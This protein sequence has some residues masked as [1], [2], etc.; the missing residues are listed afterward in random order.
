MAASGHSKTLES[1][2]LEKPRFLENSAGISFLYGTL[3]SS[4][5]WLLPTTLLSPYTLLLLGTLLSSCALLLLGYFLFS[6][7]LLLLLI[8]LSSCTLLLLAYFF[9]C[10][11]LLLLGTLL[12]SCILLLLGYFLLLHLAAATSNLA[13][14]LDL[15]VLFSIICC[16]FKPCSC[17]A[18]CSCRNL[19]LVLHL[20]AAWIHSLVLHLAAATSNLALGLHLAVLAFC[21]C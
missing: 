18:F 10:C 9:L 15:A 16:C 3:L 21:C 8:L 13:F 12:S 20:A 19:A 7:I 4:C 17:L 2:F 6:S 14:V 5:T 1:Y 11:T